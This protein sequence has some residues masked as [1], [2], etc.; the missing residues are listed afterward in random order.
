MRIKSSLL[1]IALVAMTA[2]VT[3]ARAAAGIGETA[4]DFTLTDINGKAHHLSEFKGKVVV[5]EWHNP[6]CPFVHKHYDS[7]NLPALQRSATASGAIWLTIN[8]GAPDQEG[9]N[10]TPAQLQEYL[11]QNKAAPTAYL[12]DPDG[13]V[14][15]LFGAKTTPH[16]FVISAEGKL[17]YSGAI[18]S[19]RSADAGDIPAAKNYVA[20]A[21][22]DLKAGRPVAISSTRPYGCGVKY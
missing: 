11:L 15:R 17:A 5:L 3:V 21:L 10:Y 16:M 1:T 19:V 4:P 7:G 2:L 8:S 9:G 18:D 14:G 6:D 20:A 22:A 12:L 13:K